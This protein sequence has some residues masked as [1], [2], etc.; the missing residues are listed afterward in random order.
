MALPTGAWP[1]T[2]SS[3]RARISYAAATC[4]L[5]PLMRRIIAADKDVPFSVRS[6]TVGRR[7]NTLARLQRRRP[8]PGLSVTRHAVADG[9]TVETLQIAD[10]SARLRD[11]AILYF[12]GGGFFMG[13]L[14]SHLHVAATL[15]RRAHRPV[16]HVDYRQH[17]DCTIAESI[18][19][20]VTAYRWLLAQGAGPVVCVGDS[21]GGF[22]AFATALRAAAEGLPAPAGVVG[23]SPLLE[24]DGA[25]RTAHAN[26]SRD[27]FVGAAVVASIIDCVG[28]PPSLND[29]LSPLNGPLETLPPVL[30]VAAES[31]LL[32]CDAE[33]MYA[34]LTA[35]GRPATLKIWPN[36][37]H[38]FPAL[39][40]FLPESKAAFATIVRFIRACL[41]E[42]DHADNTAAGEP[43]RGEHGV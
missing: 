37:L 3:I 11:G 13:S 15:A 36:Q 32:R 14:D 10:C 7:I 18:D 6:A 9:V 38:A 4:M 21:A 17:P 43:M 31:E 35:I 28:P 1:T 27:P 20:C 33:R 23:I 30:I 24:L 16:V 39:L 5:P 42:P 19:D 34:A 8:F 2:R 12:H 26:A 41:D 22:L 29:E 40:P 25:A